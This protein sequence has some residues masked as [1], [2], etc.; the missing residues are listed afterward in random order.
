MKFGFVS[1]LAL[2]GAAVAA[3]SDTTSLTATLTSTTSISVASGCSFKNGLTATA[4]SDLDD[5]SGCEAVSGDITISGDLGSASIANVRAIYGDLKIFNSSTITQFA[6]DSLTTITGTLSLEQLTILTDLS[7]GSLASVGAISYVTLPNLGETGLSVVTECNSLLFSD[8]NIASLEGVNPTHV[9]VFNINNNREMTSVNSNIET[10]SSALTV[11]FN[12]DD[13]TVEFPDLLWANNM[14]FYSVSSVSI[15]EIVAINKSAGFFE[16]SMEELEFPLVTSIGGD[17]TIENNED[18]TSVDFSNV[19]KLGGGLVI[20]NNTELSSVS[21]D[22]LK[23]ITGAVTIDGDFDNVT[24]DSLRTVRGSFELESDGYA[25]CS[26]FKSLAKNGGIQ[27]DYTCSA[28][29]RSSSKKSSKTSKSSASA[30]ATDSSSS[31]TSS[32]GSDDSSSSATGSVSSISS[33]STGGAASLHSGSIFA[34]IAA[35][36][37]SLL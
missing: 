12:G 10:I 35:I 21:F 17:L 7:F 22:E 13:T 36:F 30:S 26:P 15:P 2:A 6:A 19:T 1:A 14:T 3:T 8:T 27:G 29:T 4:Q 23:S 31:A 34:T 5:I 28:K 9:E 32:S 11:A 16:S 18:L 20:V 25:D 37:M 33:S 24:M